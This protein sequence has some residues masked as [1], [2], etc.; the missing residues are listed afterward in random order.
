MNQSLIHTTEN[1]NIYIYDNQRRLSILVHPEFENAYTKSFN[2]DPYYLKKYAYLKNHGFFTKLDHVDFIPLEESIVK[3]NII[4]TKQIVFEVTDSCNLKCTYCAL[5]ELYDAVD[6]RI[7]KK[8]NTHYAENLLKYIF[9]LKPKCE[10]AQLIIGFYGGE[11]LLNMNFIKH[12]VE[13]AHQLNSEKKMELLYSMTT[14][15]TL[16]DKHIDFLASNNFRLLI[17]L[18]GDEYNHSYRIFDKSKNNSFQK[19]IEN[20]DL[21]KRNYPE[22]FSDYV[23]FNAVLHNRNSVKNIYEFIYMRYHK[24]PRISELNMRDIREEKRDTLN[25]MFHHIRKSEAEFQKEES[26]LSQL[27]HNNSSSY[28]ELIDFLKYFSVNYYISN[29][30]ALLH[31]VEKQLPTSTCTPFSKKIF[32]TNRNKLLP[33]ERVNY[34]YSLGKMNEKMEVDISDI[35]QKYNFYYNHLMKFCQTCYLYRFCGTCLFQEDNID[36][37]DKENFVCN[38]YHDLETFKN[39]LYHIYSFIEKYPNDF[40]NILENTVLE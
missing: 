31:D 7:G 4:N 23:D 28:R 40:S 20:V 19:V 37:V 11:A 29:M 26:D 18:D 36:N 25:K 35:T 33:C 10:N 13:V 30:S 27:A 14:N 34:K 38:S 12:I 21:I 3:E 32:L 9:G 16:I 8:I 2:A 24:I 22:Y 15:A 6:E 17:S 5:G 1:G 39:K